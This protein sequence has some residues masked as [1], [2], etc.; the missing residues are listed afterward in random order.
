[1]AVKKSP[2]IKQVIQNVT[3]LL[4]QPTIHQHTIPTKLNHKNP[5]DV[6]TLSTGLKPLD[7]ALGVGGLPYSHITELI[8]PGVTATSGGTTC[9]AARIASKVQRQQEVVTIVDMSR[10]FD[11]WQ[12]ERCGLIAPQLLLTRPD[13]VFEALTTIES[14][15]QNAQ[16]VIVA[17]GFVAGLLRDIESGL[18]KTLLRRMQNIIK[19]SQSAFIFITNPAKNSPF[20]PQIYPAGFPLAELADVRMWVQEESWTYNEGVS[21]AYKANLTV[22]KNRLAMAGKGADI[23]I[24]FTSP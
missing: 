5:V 8:G 9:I 17:M 15:A 19:H 14:A 18:L 20:D 3:G 13:T 24:K 7:K 23:K 21:T 16:L 1:M 11:P 22:I 4:A 6:S 12:A 10:N 2:K